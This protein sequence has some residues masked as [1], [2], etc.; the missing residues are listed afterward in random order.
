[1]N[2]ITSAINVSYFFGFTEPASAGLLEEL[3]LGFFER[4]L[5]RCRGFFKHGQSTARHDRA[6]A[7]GSKR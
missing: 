3:L 7:I 6:R 1:M 2:A 5:P 4:D